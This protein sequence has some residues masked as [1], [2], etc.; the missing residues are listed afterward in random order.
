MTGSGIPFEVEIRCRFDSLEEAYDRLPFLPESLDR[1][2]TWTSTFYGL[3]MFKSGRL[4]RLTSDKFDNSGTRYFLGWKGPDI[5]MFANIRREL[6]EEITGGI[7]NSEILRQLGSDSKPAGPEEV[8]EELEK[9]GHGHFMAFQGNDESGYDEQ[10]EVHV[11]VMHCPVIEWPLLV[12]L[13]KSANTE[14]EARQC[15]NALRSLCGEY[16]LGEYL[17]KEEPPTLLYTRV[18]GDILPE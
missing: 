5:G 16:N 7:A 15:E 14:E 2:M 8:A 18:F 9:L 6:D 10:H 17:V 11:K 4:L 3:D 1:R 13:E 12:E